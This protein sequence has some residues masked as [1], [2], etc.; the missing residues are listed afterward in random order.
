MKVGHRA[1]FAGRNGKAHFCA[2][3]L[4]GMTSLK[5]AATS[6]TPHPTPDNAE[7]GLCDMQ[8]LGMGASGKFTEAWKEK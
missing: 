8:R 3:T 1:S 7:A 2:A 5:R 6:A 4:L